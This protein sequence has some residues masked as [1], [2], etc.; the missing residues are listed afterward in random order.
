[1]SA[2]FRRRG[3]ARQAIQFDGTNVSECA[4]L[5]DYPESTIVNCVRVGQWLV[6][7]PDGFLGQHDD[8]KF[9]ELYVAD[10]LPEPA[11]ADVP[12]DY[13]RFAVAHPELLSF[14]EQIMRVT[15]TVCEAMIVLQQ[16]GHSVESIVKRLAQDGV[17][18]VCREDGTL[19]SNEDRPAPPVVEGGK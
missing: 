9:Q 15:E 12:T 2:L 17:I 3:E 4:A 7:G 14:E 1:M 18:L 11:P 6:V 8:A 5:I 19:V 10:P 16:G 13:E